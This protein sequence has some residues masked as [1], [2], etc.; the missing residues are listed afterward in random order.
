MDDKENKKIDINEPENITREINLDEL[1]DG[2]INNTVVIDPLTKDEVLLKEKKRN[3]KFIFIIIIVIA[4]LLL[5]YLNNNIKKD[6]VIKED[7]NKTTNNQII[8]TTKINNLRGTLN[9]TYQSKSDSDSQS[10]SFTANYENNKIIDSAFNYDVISLNESASDVVKNLIDQYEEFYINNASITGN[11]ISFEKNDKGFTFNIKTDY[12]IFKFDNINVLDGKTVLYA[13]P[14]V[15][16]TV[17]NLK[18]TYESKGF[19]CNIVESK[20][21]VNNE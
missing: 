19:T 2:V 18:S 7:K 1:Y 5:Y 20:E 12:S 3:F 16:D 9:C 17:D 8:T 13:K 6:V 14:I 21:E 15:D 4:L 10:V 11:N